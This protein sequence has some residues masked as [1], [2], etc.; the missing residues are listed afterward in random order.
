ME[1]MG[2]SSVATARTYY[3]SS[4][5]DNLYYTVWGGNDIHIG[6]YALPTESIAAAS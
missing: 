4:P 1:A 3:N 2:D 5:A 6:L